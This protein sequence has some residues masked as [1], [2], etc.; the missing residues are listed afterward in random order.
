MDDDGVLPEI[1]LS[2]YPPIPYLSFYVNGV[3]K[4]ICNLNPNKP[5]GPDN[6]SPRI[7]KLLA[8]ELSPVLTFLFQQSY[9]FG[10]LPDDWSKAL[11]TPVYKKQG[12]H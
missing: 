9:D 3:K 8:N 12:F 2:D 1:G 7:L 4:Q 6:L 11:V 5:G 10:R